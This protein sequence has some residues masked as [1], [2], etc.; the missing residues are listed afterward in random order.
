MKK[1]ILLFG[2][3]TLAACSGSTIKPD[4]NGKK[5]ENGQ[6]TVLKNPIVTADGLKFIYRLKAIPQHDIFLAGGFNGWNPADKSYQL[7]KGADG[8]WSATVKIDKGRWEY[9]FVVDG[10]QY[11]DTEAKELEPDGTGGQKSLVSAP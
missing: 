9:K 10:Q 5:T 8:T 6:N 11:S 7:S 4:G 3:L 2:I 1:I